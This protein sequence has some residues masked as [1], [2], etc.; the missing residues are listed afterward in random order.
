M[1]ARKAFRILWEEEQE[2]RRRAEEE[3]KRK[4]E[5]ERLRKEEEER[6]RRE[7]EEL[8]KVL[9]TTRLLLATVK[10]GWQPS[11]RH[12][13]PTEAM[14]CTHGCLVVTASRGGA[15]SHPRGR[16]GAA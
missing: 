4:E 5:E 11:V 2:R 1:I 9:G 7:A 14:F 10:A 12:G 15:A 16:A 3:R 6:L 13:A 8:A